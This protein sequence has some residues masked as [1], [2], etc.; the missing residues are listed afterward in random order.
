MGLVALTGSILIVL[1]LMGVV[2]RANDGIAKA[3]SQLCESL[4]YRAA[5]SA[6]QNDYASVRKL[7]EGAVHRNEDLISAG[8]R[9]LDGGLVVATSEHRFMWVPKE[10]KGST[11]T[12][13]RVAT[14]QG[15]IEVRMSEVVP[16][17]VLS[18]LWSRPLVR[19]LVLLGGIGFVVYMLYMRRM[20]RHLDPSA[21][22]P[23]RV[24]AALDVMAEGVLLLDRNERIVLANSSFA[25][26]IDR[27]PKDLL[28]VCASEL[29]WRVPRSS[30][31]P[32]EMPWAKAVRD[33]EVQM[34]SPLSVEIM[35]GV[36]RTF[37]VNAAPVGDGR[38][39]VRGAIVTFDDITALEKK[40]AE[41][42]HALMV[43][44]LKSAELEEALEMLEKSRDEI[45]T[46]NDELLVLARCDPL[47]GISNRRSFMEKAELE[48]E[49][50]KREG[51]HLS[52]LMADIDHFKRVNDDH[53][54]S[55]GDEVICRTAE[56]LMAEV[57]DRACVCRYGG[58]EF[59]VLLIDTNTAKAST[60]GERLR[61]TMAAG[62][63][64]SVPV[65]ASFGVSS[66]AFGADRFQDLVNQAD[67]AL[68]ASKEGGRNRVTCWNAIGSAAAVARDSADDQRRRRNR[69]AGGCSQARRRRLTPRRKEASFR[70]E[71]F[72]MSQDPA[73]AS[74][75]PRSGSSPTSA[76]SPELRYAMC[77]ES[78]T[79]FSPE[80]RVGQRRLA[81]C[82]LRGP[83]EAPPPLC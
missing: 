45:R 37:M 16:P 52:V 44:E 73:F 51:R 58:E 63:F 71:T 35:P 55:V 39:R 49:T 68:Y 67:E 78:H 80:A 17:G 26:R 22:I 70:Q 40:S 14:G 60:V 20:L 33:S 53:G 15:I 83:R 7:L 77:S 41:L 46:Q 2:P 30:A 48:F 31:R 18:R 11:L 76:R 29:D 19:L 5:E 47:T 6:A 50:A 9:S 4:A 8:L 43:G 32:Q 42:E 82:D 65:T 54:H 10:K 61:R 25:R 24:Q 69:V 34:A 57:P 64:A 3:R 36:V 59:C 72:G 21:V 28:G 81:P 62:G 12:H 1:D 27:A 66:V 79:I 23:P 38:D 13:V 74:G 56:A 75:R